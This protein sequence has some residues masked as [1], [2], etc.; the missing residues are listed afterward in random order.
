MGA[1]VGVSARTVEGWE[2]GH[3][4]PGKRAQK[5]LQKILE[6]RKNEVHDDSYDDS[7]ENQTDESDDLNP[8]YVFST[9]HTE[10][11]LKL[12]IGAANAQELACKTMASRGLGRN[13]E[14]VGF[15][16]AKKEWGIDR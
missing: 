5:L 13:G 15:D 9:I 10:L 11:L 6:G 1:A 12:A 16:Q 4:L 3:H 14:W 8:E 2:K 7:N